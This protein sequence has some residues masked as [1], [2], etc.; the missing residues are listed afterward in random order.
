[1]A[2]FDQYEMKISE[3]IASLEALKRELDEFALETGRAQA[4]FS[5]CISLDNLKK[6][7]EDIHELN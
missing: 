6:L 2:K 5:A 4:L 1:M 7:K 3:M